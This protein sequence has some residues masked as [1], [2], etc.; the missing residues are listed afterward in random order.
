[1]NNFIV[2]TGGPGSGKTSVINRLKALNYQCAP[3]VGRKVIQ[4]Q[5][6]IHGTALPWADK[7]AFRDAMVREDINNY[8]AYRATQQPVFFD[9][10]II[11]CYGY[12]MLEGLTVSD[13]FM[14]RCHELTYWQNVFIFPPWE[15]IFIN[16][17]E[18]KQDFAL[19]VATYEEMVKAYTTF[20]YK[21]IE[22]PKKSVNE[23]VEFI[24]TKIK[25]PN[26]VI[27]NY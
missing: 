9:R 22:V 15:S 7:A 18:R 25:Q 19:A 12:S 4:R 24:L 8:H 27:E 5:V 23:R 6:E 1:M 14:N 13:E 2:F 16:D 11:D 3:E 26:P 10:S 21:L 20:G 17:A